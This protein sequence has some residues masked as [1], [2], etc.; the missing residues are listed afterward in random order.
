MATHDQQRRIILQGTLAGGFAVAVP[1]LFGCGKPETPPGPVSTG[2]AAAAP[3]AAPALTEPA[4]AVAG[5]P[6]AKVS[7][8]SVKYQDQPKG[9][10]RC[11]NCL[12]FIAASSTCK[13]VDGQIN[14]DGWCLLWAKQA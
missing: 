10:Q 13:L 14:P 7:K 11:G 4:R 5:E 6:A 3:P 12:H 8:E 1:V 9:E 2:E